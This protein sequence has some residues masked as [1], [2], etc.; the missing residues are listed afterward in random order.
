MTIVDAVVD[1]YSLSCQS[2][3]QHTSFISRCLYL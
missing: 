2:V 3:L 1:I